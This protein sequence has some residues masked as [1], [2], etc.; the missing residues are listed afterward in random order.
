LETLDIGSAAYEYT[1]WRWPVFPLARHGKAPAIPKTKG[2]KGF[3]DA[4]TD[5]TRIEKWW[6][7]HPDHNIGLATGHMF[8]VIDIDTKDS[9]GNPSSAGVMSFMELLESG[10]IPECHG[11]AITAS[12]GTHLFVKAT[13][14]GN[15]AGIRPG[16]DYRGLGGYVVAAPSTLGRPG[17]SYSWLVEPSPII[18]GGK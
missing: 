5:S 1:K 10:K 16:I 12:G 15:Y 6:D 11:V 8:D 17:R 13:G 2:G 3:K 18:K 7:R 9:D 4:T 14:K